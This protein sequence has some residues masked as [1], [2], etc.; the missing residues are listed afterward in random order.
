MGCADVRR[1]N[2]QEYLRHPW[3]SAD[4]LR[5]GLSK[6][7]VRTQWG[8]PAQRRVLQVDQWGATTEEWIYPGAIAALPVQYMYL[9]R[10]RHL[11][12]EGD[13]LVRWSAD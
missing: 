7:A 9:S 10:T 5:V 1:P 12:F 3:T 11:I 13:I 8:E 4:D 6:E 2:L